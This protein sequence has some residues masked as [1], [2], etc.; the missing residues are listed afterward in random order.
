M[1]VQMCTDT[2]EKIYRKVE[3]IT[4]VIGA[5]GGSGVELPQKDQNRGK[6]R[7]YYRRRHLPGLV[8]RERIVS[9]P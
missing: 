9:S 7:K 8:I 5:G 3:R 1:D 4:V 2:H 6:M